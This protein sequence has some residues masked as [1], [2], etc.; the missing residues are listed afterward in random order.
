MSAPFVG[1]ELE[2][3]TLS[4]QLMQTRRQGASAAALI[5]GEPGS[6]KSRLLGEFLRLS[7]TARTVRV[8]GFEPSQSIPLAAAGDLLHRLATSSGHGALLED[9]VF[10]D[11]D[12]R[13]RD[14]LRIF[15]A[16]HRALTA[17]GALVLAIDDLQWVDEQSM[18]LIHY[19][20]RA[21]AP[22]GPPL[23]VVAAARPSPAAAAF[24]ASLEAQIPTERRTFIELGPLPLADGVSL[25]R[26]IDDGIDEHAAGE[27]WRRA[28]GSPFWL[29][30]LARARG[31]DDPASLIRDRLRALSGAAGELLAALSVVAHPVAAGD[32]ARMLGWEGQ[33]VSHTARELIARGLA[34]DE[35]GSLHLAHDLIR[36]AATRSLPPEH[37]RR[38][39]VALAGVIEAEAGDDL[40][41]LIEALEHRVAAGEAAA[42]LA[43]RILASP[44]RRLLTADGLRLLASISDGLEGAP[45]QLALDSELGELAEILGEQELA[46][47]RWGR[48]TRHSPA[49]PVRQHAEIESARAAYRLGRGVEARA[50]LD[51]ARDLA[52][53]AAAT[54]VEVDALQAEIE[55]W[56]DH[57][58]D[59]GS[60]TAERALTSAETMASAAGGMDRLSAAERHAYLAALEA[61]TDAALQE[62]R[63]DDVLRL[64]EASVRV[65]RDLD[66]ATHLAALVRTGFA[67]RPLGRIRESEARY[68]HAW[69]ISR[70]LVF[71]TAMVDAGHGLA[72]SLRDLGRLREAREVAAETVQLEARL[73]HAH[74]RWGNA[75]SILHAI[76]LSLGDPATALR[77]LRA[78]AESETDPH[79]RIAIYQTIAAWQARFVGSQAAAE[80]DVA[81]A[82]ARASAAVARCPRCSAELTIVSVELHA[83]TGRLAEAE[84]ELAAWERRA[85]APYLM[86]QLW[87]ARAAAAIAT[88]ARDDRGTIAILGPYAQ[89]LEG[90]GLLED[91]LW[92]RLDLGRAFV[93]IDR[94][95]SVEQFAQA[96]EL[97]DSIGAASQHRL[98]G[99]AL[100]SLGVRAWRRGRATHGDRLDSLSQR[101]R[102][103]VH[104]VADGRSNREIAEALLVSPKTVERHL[105]N[106][107]AKLGLRNRTELAVLVHG[108]VRGSPDE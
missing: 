17:L 33:R 91:L 6:G 60:R 75:P 97:A 24:R 8:V 40:R 29:E 26:A 48:V 61:A 12:P 107:L 88:A 85:T 65:A 95:R 35:L 34:L 5:T 10:G 79:Y 58:T 53:L 50:H 39:H 63:A 25:A 68:R 93:R 56:L 59:A 15:E 4:G 74:R 2:L 90:A 82:G 87:R 43:L 72:R 105:T 52:P 99:Q 51:R 7:D 96:A 84:R 46:I 78:D 20:Q 83:R 71:P 89:E 38:L 3:R 70:R 67:L 28:R 27:L 69:E 55:L 16:A 80:V 49:P 77:K 101:E 1:R 18:A 102:E 54:A 22:E 9:L 32:V 31:T 94:Q 21:S 44:R 66:E 73:M 62:D 92:A 103:V 14:P 86:R 23:V 11:R 45:E 47:D 100:R 30:V 36:E 57:V 76:E 37:R 98:S 42:T 64:A 104:L 41:M 81:L 106:V 108:S 19:M 13:S